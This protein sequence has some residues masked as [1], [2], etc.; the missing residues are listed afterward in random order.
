MCPCIRVCPLK[1]YVGHLHI[2][3]SSEFTCLGASGLFCTFGVIPLQ[4]LDWL[5]VS[6]ELFREK[7]LLPDRR[8]QSVNDMTSQRLWTR[9]KYRLMR[10]QM[11]IRVGA[12]KAEA[13]MLVLAVVLIA[14]SEDGAETGTK[15]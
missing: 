7:S 9:E 1:S 13:I 14:G 8:G 11:P 2:G 10:Q 5:T 15:L 12:T 3:I 6:S 4:L